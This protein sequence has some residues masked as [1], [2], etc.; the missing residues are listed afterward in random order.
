MK[1][2]VL[3]HLDEAGARRKARELAAKM[4]KRIK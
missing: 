1:D 4:W 3:P 2:G